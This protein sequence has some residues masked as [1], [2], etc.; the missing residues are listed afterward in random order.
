MAAGKST[1]ATLLAKIIG[2]PNIPMDRVRWYYYIKDGFSLEHES[3]LASFAEQ[4]AYWK[5][6]EVK[7]ASRIINEFPNA[8]IDFGAGHSVYT[9]PKQLQEVSELLAPIPNV[10]LLLPCEDRERSISICNERLVSK[11]KGRPME[12]DEIDANRLFVTHESNY[13]LAKR[14]I[15]TESKTAQ[16]VAEEIAA[17]I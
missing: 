17:L 16:Q 2:R 13:I 6:F 11:K 15:F 8:V 3:S 5:P 4:M 7:A 9:D 14:V 10:Y 1:V 12:Q